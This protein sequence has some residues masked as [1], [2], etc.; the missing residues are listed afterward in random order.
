MVLEDAFSLLDQAL[1]GFDTRAQSCLGCLNIGNIFCMLFGH[2]TPAQCR[3]M[4]GAQ[5]MSWIN[6]PELPKNRFALVSEATRTAF[7]TP[8]ASVVA[9]HSSRSSH[10]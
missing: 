6:V 7:T 9:A 3:P 10:A 1:H 4:S 2:A 8:T 5:H